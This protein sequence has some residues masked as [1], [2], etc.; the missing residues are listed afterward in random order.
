MK[1]EAIIDAIYARRSIRKFTDEAVS[2]S[3]LTSF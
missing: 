3:T 1:N 2:M